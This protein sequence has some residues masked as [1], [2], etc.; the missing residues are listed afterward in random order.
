MAFNTWRR[1]KQLTMSGVGLGVRYD[2]FEVAYNEGYATSRTSTVLTTG[3][4]DTNSENVVIYGDS[5]ANDDV[6]LRDIYESAQ[7]QL[8]PSRFPISDAIVKESKFTDEFPNAQVHNYGANW[9]TVIAPDIAEPD[10]GASYNADPVYF[11]DDSN[12]CGI[13]VA[14]GYVL[15]E[16]VAGA[17][18]DELTLQLNF[19]V[20][21]GAPLVPRKKTTRRM[22]KPKSKTTRRKYTRRAKK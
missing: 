7:P 20:S 4:S 6:S 11:Q 5:T 19:T 3:M 13:I 9:S 18:E 8:L 14:K 12:L 1:Q 17:I 10:S 16:D 2:D 22:T 21:I 15:A